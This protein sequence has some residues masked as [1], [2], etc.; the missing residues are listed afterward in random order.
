[1]TI[2]VKDD[3]QQPLSIQH[4]Q[5]IALL[6]RV[7]SHKT[8]REE[9]IEL[10]GGLSE[11]DW[12][13]FYQTVR[14]QGFTSLLYRRLKELGDAVVVPES[15]MTMM[16]ESV[17]T[18]TT[19]NMLMLHEAGLILKTLRSKKLEVMPLKGLYL[20]ENVY[21]DISLRSFSDLDL[22][23]HTDDLDTVIACMQGIGYHLETYFSTQDANQDIKHVPPMRG[24]DGQ[25]VEIHWSILEENEPFTIN[26]DGIWARA[27]PARVTGVD[28]LA[29]SVE[30]LLL[31]LCVHLGYQHRLKIGLRGLYDIAEVLHHF[32]GQIDWQKVAEIAEQW[33]VER[34]IWLVLKLTEE[35]LGA[36]VPQDVYGWLVAEAVADKVLADAKAQL[37]AGEGWAVVM[38]PDL[39]RLTTVRGIGAKVKVMLSRVFIPRQ[40][41]ARLYNVSPRSLAIVWCYFRRFRDLVK[42]YGPVLKPVLQK[43]EAV[44]VGVAEEQNSKRLAD[45]MGKAG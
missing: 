17:L 43:E 9:L 38:T 29:L 34:V 15:I 20:V 26:A 40:V 13:A 16:H 8:S 42:Q 35:M 11:V 14:Q 22:L 30:D 19:R 18:A 6:C 25:L 32:M 10:F 1:M 44:M 12:V 28:V 37:I 33:G 7:L 36:E 3:P 5:V 45:W 31:H 2:Q 24:P 4:E 21:K 39:A 41:L 23:V 27:V